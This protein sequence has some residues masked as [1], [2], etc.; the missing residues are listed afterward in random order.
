MFGRLSAPDVLYKTPE[1]G[2]IVGMDVSAAPVRRYFDWAAT[3]L[4]DADTPDTRA[5]GAPFGNPSSA[6]REGREA[7]A[8]LEKA[9]TR[10]AAALGAR[11]E[12]LF[13]TSGGTESNA[14]VLFSL[15]AGQGRASNGADKEARLLVP[16]GEH[17]SVQENA[18]ALERLG[19]PCARAGLERDGRVSAAR[20]ASALRKNPRVRMAAVMAVN[21]ETGAIN[22]I[23]ALSSAAAEAAR[24]AERPLHL[25]CDAVQ[26]AGKIPLD[27]ILPFVDSAAF[28]AHKLGGPRGAGLLFL[29]RPLAALTRGGGQEGGI[30]PGTENTAGA[31]ALADCL[32]RRAGAAAL[33]AARTN[34]AARMNALLARLGTLPR[35]TP[36]PAERAPD[37]PRF[38]PW[39][40]QAAFTG[41]PGEVMVR[42]L[43]T[44]GFAVSTGSAC[45]SARKRRPV[46]E[47]MGV[48]TGTALSGIR[49]SQG[50]STTLED[51]EALAEAIGQLCR[52]L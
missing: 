7:R 20:F 46:L 52:T 5:G 11:P 15:L 44:A 34:A 17:P 21:N 12:E 10:C 30:R 42:A 40:L 50:W 3:A 49:I 38:S 6:H 23:A 35:F 51:I 36:I 33:E 28:S 24:N 25:H 37:D 1:S 32:E 45:S 14:I 9:R 4:P 39:I 22:D 26:A 43:D 29:R 8:F 31:G 41:I 13:F 16:A 27:T 18:A 19:V 47:A 2:Y 48:D